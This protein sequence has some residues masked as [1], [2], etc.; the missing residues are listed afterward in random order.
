MPHTT[1]LTEDEVNHF[2]NVEI[3]MPEPTMVKLRE[4]E[5]ERP[6]NLVEFNFEDVKGIA[7]ALRKPR[8]LVPSSGNARASIIPARGVRIGARALSRLEA[9]IEMMNYYETVNHKPTADQLRCDPVVKN[10]KLEFDA[11]KVRKK[12]DASAL[13]IGQ[14]LDVVR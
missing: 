12:K 5:I 7:E 4:E 13:L 9:D 1:D 2:F 14:K 6:E 10:F 8:G 3:G 11:L